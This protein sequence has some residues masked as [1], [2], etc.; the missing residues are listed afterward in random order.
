M[1]VSLSLG[2]FLVMISALIKLIISIGIIAFVILIGPLAGIWSLNTLF[3]VLVI[4]YTWETW[5]A[6]LLLFGSITPAGGSGNFW[7]FSPIMSSLI[8]I[9]QSTG[10]TGL[11]ATTPSGEGVIVNTDDF[12]ANDI[13]HHSYNA[14]KLVYTCIF[15]YCLISLLYNKKRKRLTIFFVNCG[16]GNARFS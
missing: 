1:L 6:F 13:P 5:L 9:N 10:V 15:L 12:G 7:Q 11:L 16:Y 14:Y 4:P 8:D 2:G 3:P